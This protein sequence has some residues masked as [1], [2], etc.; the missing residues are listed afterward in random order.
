MLHTV[1]L[2]LDYGESPHPVLLLVVLVSPRL[3]LASPSRS[4]RYLLA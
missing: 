3:S 1:V 4:I 2:V